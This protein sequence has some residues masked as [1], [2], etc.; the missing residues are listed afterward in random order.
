[1]NTIFIPKNTPSSKNSKQIT[2]SGFIVHSKQC[3]VYYK[4]TKE[5]WKSG[6]D[7]F[8]KLIKDKEKPYRVSFKFVRDSKRKFDY[9]N[10]LQTIL[11]QMVKYE[12]IEDD[13]MLE[14]LPSFEPY[15]YDK[16]NPGCYIEV[17]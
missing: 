9:V 15:D 1:M 7:I 6:K 2:K 5:E 8:H 3:Q 16:Q 4:E 14:I 10:P 17:L 12:W 11:D 13:N